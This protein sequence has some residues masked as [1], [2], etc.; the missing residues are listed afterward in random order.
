M[1]GRAGRRGLDDKGIVILMIDQKVTP[2]VVKDMVQGKADPINSA[3]HLTYNMVSGKLYGLL[4][5]MCE[6][7]KRRFRCLVVLITLLFSLSLSH[8]RSVYNW[9]HKLN[10]TICYL[11]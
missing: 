3:F 7:F 11:L 4:W 8:S 5:Q 10:Y 9:N 6:F 2:A 1:S